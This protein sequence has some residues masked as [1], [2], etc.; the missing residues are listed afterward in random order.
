MRWIESVTSLYEYLQQH[1]VDLPVEVELGNNASDPGGLRVNVI[2]GNAE[3]VN[4]SAFDGKAKQI[5]IIEGWVYDRDRLLAYQMLNLLQEL[6]V[7]LIIGWRDETK[8]FDCAITDI[9]PD[10]DKFDP[11][12]G[13]FA[14]V[15]TSAICHD[16]SGACIDEKRRKLQ[17]AIWETSA[18]ASDTENG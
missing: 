8:Q 13:F 6:V 14:V 15:E 4:D 5:V 18:S 1:L 16:F 9:Q 3:L 2:R 10:M 11:S 7:N 17:D 12:Y